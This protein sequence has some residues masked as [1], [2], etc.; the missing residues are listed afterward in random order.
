M[1]VGRFWGTVYNKKTEKHKYYQLHK[2]Y[3]IELEQELKLCTAHQYRPIGY[4][5]NITLVPTDS[6]TRHNGLRL[7]YFSHQL[8][9][10]NTPMYKQVYHPH[11]KGGIGFVNV[12]LCVCVCL[13]TW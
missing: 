3:S 4:N 10:R 6:F 8:N 2:L 12:R 9:L 7:S 1:T 11:N 13:S 5:I